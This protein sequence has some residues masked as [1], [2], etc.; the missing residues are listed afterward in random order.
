MNTCYLG[1]GSNQKFPERQVRRAIAAIKTMPKTAL[2]KISRLHQSQAW[3][4]TR[5]QNFCNVVV[6][7]KTLLP[8]EVLLRHCQEIESSQGRV[9]KRRWGPR[10]LDIDILLYSDRR[11][12]NHKLTIPHPYIMDRDF[13][14]IPLCEISDKAEQPYP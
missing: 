5:Q 1:I 3:G 12:H 2:C 6:K 8:P 11:I 9:R 4:M 13:V 14:R 7:I 10:T